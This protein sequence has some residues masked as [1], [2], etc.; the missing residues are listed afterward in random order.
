MEY[1]FDDLANMLQNTQLDQDGYEV[2]DATERLL[3]SLHASYTRGVEIVL[4]EYQNE[5]E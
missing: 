1:E 2:T 3:E 5:R 4:F